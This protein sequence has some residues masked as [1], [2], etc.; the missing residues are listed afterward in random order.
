[1]SSVA[2]SANERTWERLPD[3]V[4]R[5]GGLPTLL[6]ATKDGRPLA[7]RLVDGLIASG[8][9]PAIQLAV[10]KSSGTEYLADKRLP[11]EV[12][13]YLRDTVIEKRGR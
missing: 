7:K 2:I 5:C 11:S 8:D 9:D 12:A 1:M 10:L 4:R 3:E 13:N 6:V